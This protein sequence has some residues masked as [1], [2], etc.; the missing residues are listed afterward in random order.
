MPPDWIRALSS[1]E[2]GAGRIVVIAGPP[3]SGKSERLGQLE[4]RLKDAGARTLRITGQYRARNTAYGAVSDLASRLE[5]LIGASSAPAPEPAAPRI[6][7]SSVAWAYVPPSEDEAPDAGPSSRGRGSGGRGRGSARPRSFVQ[8]SAADL[9]GR[10]ELAFHRGQLAQPLAFLVEDASLLDPESRD[11]LFHLADRARLR[12]VLLAVAIESTAT[13][14]SAWEERWLGRSDVDWVRLTHRT[15]DAREAKRVR[16]L[17][18]NLPVR[19]QR[20]VVC[21]ALVGGSVGDVRLSRISRLRWDELADALLPATEA[22]LLKV[23]DGRVQVGEDAWVDWLVAAAPEADRRDMHREIG[24]ALAALSPEPD[25]AR[26]REL[27]HHFHEWNRGSVA[28]R[29]WLECAEI[30]ERLGAFDPTE[31]AIAR[32]LDCVDSLPPAERPEAEAEL[33]L[34]HARVLLL[35]GRPAEMQLELHSGVTLALQSHLSA[36]RLEEWTEPLIPPLLAAGPRPS[37]M[38]TLGELGDRCAEGGAPGA[39]VIL[40]SVVAGLELQRGRFEQS[41]QGALRAF[42]L[43]RPLGRGPVL[44]LAI[45]GVAATR[46]HPGDDSSLTAR[47]LRAAQTMLE[48]SRRLELRQFA[49]VI[50]ARVKAQAGD[51]DG[52]IRIH[53]KS[54]PVVERS[55]SLPM[56]LH[57]RVARAEL[58]LRRRPQDSHLAGDLRRARQI[59]EQLHLTPPST[60]WLRLLLLEADLASGQGDTDGARERWLALA[61]LRGPSRQL[62]HT[63]EALLRLAELEEKRAAPDAARAFLEEFDRRRPEGPGGLRS[64]LRSGYERLAASL[65]SPPAPAPPWLEMDS[66]SPPAT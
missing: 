28:L 19:T 36:D 40:L 29:Y 6:A 9:W 23:R 34:F 10:I 43:A 33:R 4:R 48:S 37:L 55:R 2:D 59:A 45:L 27:A 60:L 53:E 7:E 56:E 20:L 18:E 8:L 14:F 3:E 31:E 30:S 47:F 15:T 32:A 11:Y 52:A 62:V 65:R 44:A 17:F 64:E 61:D 24:E 51:V 42:R 57:H 35:A 39:A 25:A 49:D 66:A 58:L 16:E 21:T 41:Q 38:T 50:Q 22:G 26:R 63:H 54:I 12:P 46:V 13:S 5:E 1:L